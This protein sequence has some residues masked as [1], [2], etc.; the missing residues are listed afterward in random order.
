MVSVRFA[1]LNG[2]VKMNIVSNLV[3]AEF[4]A[5]MLLCFRGCLAD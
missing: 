3:Q 2:G 1:N 4:I 5:L